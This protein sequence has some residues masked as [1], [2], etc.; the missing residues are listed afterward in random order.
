MESRQPR[1]REK[2]SMAFLHRNQIQ[3]YI[4]NT[5]CVMQWEDHVQKQPFSNHVYKNK[6]EK[7]DIHIYQAP[8]LLRAKWGKR[9][10]IMWMAKGA[11]MDDLQ[12]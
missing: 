4:S 3:K 11:R 2:T 8:R 10:M 5:G 9:P 6:E 12:T 7:F 1:Y